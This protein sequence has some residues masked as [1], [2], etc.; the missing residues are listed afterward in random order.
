MRAVLVRADP[1]DPERPLGGERLQVVRAEGLGCLG[2]EDVIIALAPYLLV[3]YAE[4]LLVPFVY[5]E[6]PAVMV[7][8]IDYAGRVPHYAAEPLLA[9]GKGVGPL[10]YLPCH[11]IEGLGKEA[12]LVAA[13]HR[14]P[15][16]VIAGGHLGRGRGERLQLPYDEP[17]E[18]QDEGGYQGDDDYRR[19]KDVE[20]ERAHRGRGLAPVDLNQEHPSELRHAERGS[21]DLHSPVILV[22]TG[23]VPF[24][25]QA[26]PDSLRIDP[27]DEH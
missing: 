8:D 13:L 17:E 21:G 22:K 3:R 19:K 25:F 10:L 14:D 9:L 4:E 16:A 11:R 27:L 24:I 5:K 15:D 12:Y 26:G 18:I 2:R 23:M 6:I 7:L 1:P 20:L